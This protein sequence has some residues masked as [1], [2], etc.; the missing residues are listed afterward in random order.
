MTS[1]YREYYICGMRIIA[2]NTLKNY[3]TK[4]PDTRLPLCEWYEKVI[5]AKWKSFKDIKRDF[6]STD[7]I[8]NQRY[9][10]NIKGNQHR[11]VAAIKF[12]PALVYIRFIGTHKEYERI[13]VKFI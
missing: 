11:L 6:N 5:K 13:N 9:V 10:F 2:L 1:A 12:I 4:H 3:W 8:G 7:Y